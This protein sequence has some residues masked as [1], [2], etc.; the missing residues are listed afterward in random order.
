MTPPPISFVSGLLL[1]IL[2]MSPSL[3]SNLYTGSRS[4][5][6]PAFLICSI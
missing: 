5:A 3:P 6:G 4:F 2:F 1:L